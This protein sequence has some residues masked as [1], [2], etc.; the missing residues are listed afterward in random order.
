MQRLNAGQNLERTITEILSGLEAGED[1]R[2]VMERL[3][4]QIV[5]FQRAGK[6]VPARLMRLSQAL[7]SECVAQSQGR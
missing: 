4:K 2:V 3:N 1:P 5:D 6:D 7:T